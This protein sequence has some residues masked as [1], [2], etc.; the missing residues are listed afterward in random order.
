M[1]ARVRA[2]GN[3][4]HATASLPPLDQHQRALCDEL[5]LRAAEFCRDD[6]EG[7]LPL[8]CPLTIE[9]T[10]RLA[11][12]AGLPWPKLGAAALAVLER[13][14]SRWEQILSEPA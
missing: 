4:Q 9:T 11:A 3:D 13:A 2:F 14:R 5:G 1:T 6:A 7:D 12:A 10:W 8:A